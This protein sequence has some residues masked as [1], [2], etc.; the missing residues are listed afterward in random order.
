MCYNLLDLPVLC[1]YLLHEDRLGILQTDNLV[2]GNSVKT[3]LVNKF[4]IGQL[5]IDSFG[6]CYFP[7][8]FFLVFGE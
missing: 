7:G 5:D 3:F 2:G 1:P 6:K 8:P 4:D